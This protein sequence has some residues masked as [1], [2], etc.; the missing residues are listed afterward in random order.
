MV[1]PITV[2]VPCYPPHQ[3]YIPDFIENMNKQIVK[4][5]KIIIALSE[6]TN[7]DVLFFNRTW[8]VISSVDF[9]VVGQDEECLAAV[10]RNYGAMF[11]ETDYILFLDADDGY[12]NNLIET[13]EKYICLEKP[14]AINYHFTFDKYNDKEY[15]KRTSQELF[16]SCFPDKKKDDMLEMYNMKPQLKY[17]FIHH[18]HICVQRKVWEMCPQQNLG[19][20][21]DSLY[22]RSILWKWYEEG[23]KGSGLIVIPEVLAKYQPNQRK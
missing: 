23:C 16:D 4:P 9:E 11:V 10:N 7:S 6:V 12:S 13:L 1:S 20:R 19:G 18:G 14:M 21:E 3:K 17:D 8:G 15:V 22:V 5:A 2:V